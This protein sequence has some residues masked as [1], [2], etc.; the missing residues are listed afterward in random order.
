MLL[1]VIVCGTSI[2][3]GQSSPS[4]TQDASKASADEPSK[5][6][7]LIRTIPLPFLK[8]MSGRIGFDEQSGRLFFSDGKNLVFISAATGETVGLVPK[9]DEV[10]DVAFAPGIHRVFVADSKRRALIFL[11]PQTL[12]I[13]VRASAGVESSSVVYDPSTKDVFTTSISSS[14]CRIFDGSTGK[15]IKAIKLR[16]YPYRAVADSRG[17][18]YFQLSP[19]DLTTL[20]H[21]FPEIGHPIPLKTEIAELDTHTLEMGKKWNTTCP[22]MLLMGVDSSGQN[23]VIGCNSS[24]ALMDPQT[25]KIL[26]SSAVTG[27]RWSAPVAFSSALGDAFFVGFDA[28]AHRQELVIVHENSTGQLGPAIVAPQLLGRPAAFDGNARY[29]FVV[30]SDTKTVD[31]GLFVGIPQSDGGI[32]PLRLPEPIPGTFRILVYGRE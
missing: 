11:D 25:R 7:H 6:Y 16:G 30:Q 15:F 28:P 32:T 1:A 22:Y 14:S 29:L 2:A 27:F 20:L 3:R 12:T 8:K 17:H 26:A 13:A 31:T 5:P 10:S 21:S 18:T 4:S 24:V 9:I 19:N 23:L